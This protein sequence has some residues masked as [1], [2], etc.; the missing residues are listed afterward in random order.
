MAF[1]QTFLDEIKE[2][3]DIA[4]VISKYVPLKR[5]GSNLTGMC[6]FHSE[7]TPSFTVFPASHNFYCFG[8]GAGGDVVTF[9]MRSE[10]MGYREAIEFL[11]QRA[12]IPMEDDGYSKSNTPSIKRE[13]IIEITTEAARFFRDKLGSPEGKIARDYIAKRGYTPLTVRRFGLGYAPNDWRQLTTHLLSKGFTEDE[14]TVAFLASRSKKNGQLYDIFRNR[15]VF[16]VFNINGEVVAFSCRRLNDEDERKYIN[17]SD[18]PA[19][20]KS[21]LLFGMHIAK[22]TPDGTL[23]LCEGA[24]DAIALHQAGFSTAV[25]T[26][27]TAIT[28]E[29]ARII[30]RYAKKVYLCYDMDAAG[31]NAKMKAI[32]ILSE[33]G[34]KA[35]IITLASDTKDPDE[36]IKKYGAAAFKSKLNDSTG[37]VDFQL[38]EILKKYDLANPDEKLRAVNEATVFI[39]TLPS[40]VTREVYCGRLS[41]KTELSRQTVIE[42]T[43]RTAMRSDKKNR[44]QYADETVRSL[45]GFGDKVN[46][47]KLKYSSVALVEESLLGMLLIVPELGIKACAELSPD[48]FITDFNK[49]VYTAFEQDFKSGT[50]PVISRDG[51][52]TAA[53]IAVI[54]RYMANRRMLGGNTPEAIADAIKRIKQEK[55]RRDADRRIEEEGASALTDYINSIKKKRR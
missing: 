54:S 28:P 3:N 44:R 27:G 38:G 10:G 21:R 8:C 42:M 20:K 30:S 46:R 16:P 41:E 51:L 26:L 19:F 2:R 5:A 23:I 4:E 48:D 36:F 45:A 31:T 18:T 6:P 39:A 7:K 25:A 34:V 17:T 37:Q 52:F 32:N 13:R 33:A 1:S 49:K 29:H 40:K 55:Y 24:A 22:N 50:E 43:E 14:L 47:D 11:A 12:G 53:E 15:L 9:I 35:E